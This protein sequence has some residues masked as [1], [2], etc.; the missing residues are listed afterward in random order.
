MSKLK[1]KITEVQ[2]LIE[3]GLSFEWIALVTGSTV[4]FV[5]EVS[6]QMSETESYIIDN[7]F[8][9]IGYE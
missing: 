1:D 4:E 3:E 8:W 9:E 5:K 6:A 7:D 2:E